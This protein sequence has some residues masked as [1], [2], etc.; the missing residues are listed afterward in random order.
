LLTIGF[1]TFNRLKYF[2]ATVESFLPLIY[3][4]K[5]RTIV[6]DNLS[7]EVGYREYLDQLRNLSPQI[8]VIEVASTHAEAMNIIVEKCSTDYLMLWPDDMQLLTNE[9]WVSDL[10]EILSEDLEVGSLSVNF[11]SRRTVNSLINP[12]LLSKARFCQILS[13]HTIKGAKI[14]KTLNGLSYVT[15]GTA[16]PPVCPSG[17]PAIHRVSLLKKIGIWESGQRVSLLDS[18]LGAEDR[19]R[20]KSN[21][22]AKRYEQAILCAPIALDIVTDQFGGKARVRGSKRYGVYPNPP[23]EIEPFYYPKFSYWERLRGN[24][25]VITAE[26][27]CSSLDIDIPRDENFAIKKASE[28]DL[29]NVQDI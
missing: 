2:R 18:S 20:K 21:K 23:K 27:I 4:K 11:L 10:C 25:F 24:S 7:S 5:I 17:I 12:P 14:K 28:I 26:D 22:Y 9:D 8:E 19:Y 6:V 16:W 3:K 15:V 1:L 29:K 13:R